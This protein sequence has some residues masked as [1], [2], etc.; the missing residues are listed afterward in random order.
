MSWENPSLAYA[1]GW[2][3]TKAALY[4]SC[5][6][7]QWVSLVFTSQRNPCLNSHGV[8]QTSIC[9]NFHCK[10][11]GKGERGEYLFGKQ[12]VGS[13]EGYMGI[14]HLDKNKIYRIG[15]H[16]TGLLQTQPK[17]MK[18]LPLITA[19]LQSNPLHVSFQVYPFVYICSHT[20]KPVTL[21]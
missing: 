17:S 13:R 7:P 5:F 21:T 15:S 3:C 14:C 12:L 10:A 19:C 6:S 20:Y 16:I 2:S 8:L 4:P 11:T 18:S 9:D 1:S